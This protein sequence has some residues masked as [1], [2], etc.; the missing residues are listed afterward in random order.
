MTS[1]ICFYSSICLSVKPSTNTHIWARTK[2]LGVPFLK[3]NLGVIKISNFFHW[4]VIITGV[5]IVGL[6][7]WPKLWPKM[8]PKILSFSPKFCIFSKKNHYKTSQ[9]NWQLYRL[10]FKGGPFFKM[11]LEVPPPPLYPVFMYANTLFVPWAFF[12]WKYCVWP[13]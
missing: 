6:K 4:F 8:W 12:T 2:V 5:G 13:N 9:K 10:N 7:N 11:G 1:N 3:K